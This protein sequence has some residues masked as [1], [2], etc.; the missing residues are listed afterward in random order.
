MERQGFRL[1]TLE[2]RWAWLSET[3]S[4]VLGRQEEIAERTLVILQ[5]QE[6]SE[7]EMR[8]VNR[9][10]VALTSAVHALPCVA[11]ERKA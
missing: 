7:S 3:L 9:Q 1:D 8:G 6:G 5:R 10:L 2:Q 11:V 4:R